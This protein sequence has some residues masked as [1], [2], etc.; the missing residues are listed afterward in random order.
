M[1]VILCLFGGR[2]PIGLKPGGA[3]SDLLFTAGNH[4][5][6][7]ARTAEELEAAE[8]TGEERGD[9]RG[10]GG[11]RGEE[12][13]AKVDSSAAH[14]AQHRARAA[15][16]AWMLTEDVGCHG[17]GGGPHKAPRSVPDEGPLLVTAA[18][19]MVSIRCVHPQGG[20]PLILPVNTR[21]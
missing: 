8:L 6:G 21:H 4:A 11:Q 18:T 12:D 14:P 15:V 5:A 7:R 19:F 10:R 20:S 16:A 17:P 1:N 2:V 3:A 13:V 9:G